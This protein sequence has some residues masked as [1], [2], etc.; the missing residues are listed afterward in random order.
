MSASEANSNSVENNQPKRI[1]T[2]VITT[3]IPHLGNYVGAIRP[4]IQ[5]VQNS[6]NEEDKSNPPTVM[7]LH[8]YRQTPDNLPRGKRPHYHLSIT[9]VID[10]YPTNDEVADATRINEILEGLTRID[11]TQWMWFH[12]RY[13]HQETGRNTYYK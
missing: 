12:R 13:K 7:A 6:T 8:T 5:S 10:N 2:G 9:P 1:L 3:G 11:P 4:A